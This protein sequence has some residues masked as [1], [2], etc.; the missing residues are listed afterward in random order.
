MNLID[1]EEKKSKEQNTKL[2]KII[3]I[4][5]VVL[6]LILV[7]VLSYSMYL[8]SKQFR[9]LINDRKTSIPSDLLVYEDNTLYISI[10]DMASLLDFEYN[11]GEYKKFDEDVTKGYVEDKTGFEAAGFEAN[12]EKMYKV[13]KE[14]DEHEDFTIKTKV[15]SINGKFYTTSEGIDLLF[16]TKF[17]NDQEKNYMSVYTLDEIVNRYASS[18]KNT[19]ITS[20]EMT[21]AN[22]KALKYGLI[23]VQ[24]AE[25]LYGVNSTEN[26]E[27][28]IGTRY[29]EMRFLE[30]TQD[31]I[32]TTKEKKQGIKSAR[33]S[34]D[35]DPAYD[36]IKQLDTNYNLYIIKVGEKYGVI[37]RTKG[38]K[39]VIYPQYDS[40]GIDTTNFEND[41]ISN[42]YILFDNCIPVKQITDTKVDKW[43]IY[44][45]DGKNITNTTYDGLRI[46]GRN[47]KTSKRK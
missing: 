6:V 34:T 25:G 31:F 27:S 1:N 8:Q 37:N 3:I 26:N 46:C 23:L 2:L 36:E 14:Y 18:L 43:T 21:F 5:I 44:D 29:T 45:K 22:K 19:V 42:Q 47:I 41:E 12:S 11:N 30:S 4:A 35:I 15:K 24:N 10:K 13:V 33:G 39:Y 16:N 38:A 28:V 7:A 17:I 40:I 20:K 9:F 32:V